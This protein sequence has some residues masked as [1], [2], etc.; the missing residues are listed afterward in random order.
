MTTLFAVAN[1][2]K[3]PFSPQ[4]LSVYYDFAFLKFVDLTVQYHTLCLKML[5]FH[6]S[7]ISIVASYQCYHHGIPAQ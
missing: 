3:R 1:V 6:R 5:E 4:P 2:G 7:K